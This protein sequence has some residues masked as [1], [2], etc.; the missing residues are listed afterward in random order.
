MPTLKL[1]GDDYIYER[2]S[3]DGRLTSYKVRIRR[4]GF[5]EQS[6]SFD[7]LDEARAFVRQILC[8]HDNGHRIDRLA[9]HRKTVGNVID[10]AIDALEN[11]RRRVKGARDELYRLRAFR[12]RET[13]LCQTIMAELTEDQFEDWLAQRLEEVA[14]STALREIRQLKPIFRDAARQLNLRYS[15]MDYLKGPRVMDER[16]RRISFD[17]ENLIFEEL[18]QA[19]FA[20][21]TGCRRSELLRLEWRDYRPRAGTIWLSDA[22][23][24][25]GR[26]I[27][28]TK[29]AQQIVEE[30]R[31][32]SDGARIFPVTGE[33]LK[34]AFEYA[35]ARAAERCREAGRPE[36]Q[37]VATLRWHDFRHEAIS[38]CF[39]AGWTSE[40]VM[41]FSG[42]VDIKSLLR[43]RHPRIDTAVSRLRDLETARALEA[44]TKLPG[45]SS[46]KLSVRIVGQRVVVDSDVAA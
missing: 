3:E 13:A 4:K 36:L 15:P 35:R 21:E 11:G 37:V 46:Q 14:P 1:K 12:R 6:R 32:M 25:R 44:T 31:Q 34:K 8:D 30:M 24:G 7:D 2:I 18:E 5:P 20:L 43:Y 29:R 28:L 42:R 45:S 10:D 38:R 9:G 22:K 33:L 26:D 23:N 39:D 40:Q 41:D 17:E 19:Q 16:I 27:L